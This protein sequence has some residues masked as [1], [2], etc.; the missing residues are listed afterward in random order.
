MKRFVVV[1]LGHFGSWAARALHARGHEVVA[2]ERRA[3]LVDRH[4]EGVTRGVVG[5][6]TD[7]SLLEEV[8][9]GSADAGVISTGGDLA[10]SILATQA[11]RDL[12]VAD[13][14]VKVTSQEAARALDSFGVT[15]TI[16]PEREAAYRLAH[17]LPSKTVM[18][19]IPLARGF[20]IQEL[21]IPDEWLGRS[22]RELAL[23]RRHGIQVVAVFD[24]LTGDFDIVPDPD[25]PLKDSDMA[26]VAGADETIAEL[27]DSGG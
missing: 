6:A 4:A 15:E 19:Y 16:F 9:A 24:V 3:D 5:D 2:V 23:R 13:I 20:S 14:Y 17:R 18:E 1:G 25:E 7:R 22:L 26:V 8:G 10:A 11:L 27:I 21:A 12:G